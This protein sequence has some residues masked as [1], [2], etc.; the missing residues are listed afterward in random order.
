M[1]QQ[2]LH[3]NVTPTGTYAKQEHFQFSLHTVHSCTIHADFFYLKCKHKYFVV[4]SFSG[5]YTFVVI[6]LNGREVRL[7]IGRGFEVLKY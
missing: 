6:R 3:C 2:V 4:S 1:P 5:L 7:I